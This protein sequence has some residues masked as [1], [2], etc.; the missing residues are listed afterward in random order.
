MADI[1][2]TPIMRFHVADYLNVTP[3]TEETIE[4][5]S[6]FNTI[7]ENP[8]AQTKETH[9]TSQKTSTVQT[10]GYKPQFPITG[11]M[12]HN[13]KTIEFIRDIAEEQKIGAETDY[14]RVRLYQPIVGKDDTFYARKFRVSIEISSIK[15]NGGEQ[16]SIDGNFNSVADVIIGEFN[17]KTKIFTV[18]TAEESSQ[19]LLGF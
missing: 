18:P 11:D 3:E 5:M 19:K 12:F 10:T 14:Y 17:T 2:K 16:M 9:Y 8:Q 7:D 6:V 15:G 1:N 13:E 4:L